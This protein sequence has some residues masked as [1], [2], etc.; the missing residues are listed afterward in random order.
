MYE[1]LLAGQQR[2]ARAKARPEWLVEAACQMS[3]VAIAAPKANPVPASAQQD[4]PNEALAL[5]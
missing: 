4:V 1:R 5:G 3:H 2:S